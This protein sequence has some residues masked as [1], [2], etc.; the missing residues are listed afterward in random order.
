MYKTDKSRYA[1][2]IEEK[3]KDVLE[4]K[5]TFPKTVADACWVLGGWKN[6]YGNKDTRLTE[7]NNGV[8]FVT[9]GN[10]EKRAIR[11]KKSPVT[12]VERRDTTQTNVAKKIQWRHQ[13]QATQ[14][15]RA[16]IS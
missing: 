3:E 14:A 6:K 8:A 7:A 15:K 10:E 16:P 9:R 13:T 2:I 5:D 12:N 4:G 11:K 1:R